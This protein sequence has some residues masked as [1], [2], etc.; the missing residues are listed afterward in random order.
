[1]LGC[2]VHDCERVIEAREPIHEP[3]CPVHDRA[4]TLREEMEYRG[5]GSDGHWELRPMV[6]PNHALFS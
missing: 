3:D 6:L 4:G 1:M 2:V 5:E